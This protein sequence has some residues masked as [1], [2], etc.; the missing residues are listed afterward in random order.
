[1]GHRTKWKN[2][3]IV[4]L[5]KE[6]KRKYSGDLWFDGFFGTIPKAQSIK[7][8]KWYKWTLLEFLKTLL[9]NTLLRESKGKQDMLNNGS[10]TKH[11]QFP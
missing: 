7:K 9:E 3:K 1:M 10:L 5:I 8:K 2:G 6:N 11:A 4:R